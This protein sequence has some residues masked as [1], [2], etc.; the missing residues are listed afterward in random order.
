MGLLQVLLRRKDGLVATL[1]RAGEMVVS[2]G[3]GLGGIRCRLG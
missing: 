2:L 1:D 3:R